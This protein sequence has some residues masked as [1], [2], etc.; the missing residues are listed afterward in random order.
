MTH[1][2]LVHMVQIQYLSQDG[3]LDAYSGRYFRDNAIIGTIPFACNSSDDKKVIIKIQ[4][5]MK[6]IKC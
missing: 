6:L 4:I 3:P 5:T 2:I 1:E